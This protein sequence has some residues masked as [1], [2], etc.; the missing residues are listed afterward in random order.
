V[1]G[2]RDAFDR[3]NVDVHTSS[4]EIEMVQR[5][6]RNLTAIYWA[7]ALVGLVGFSVSLGASLW[8]NI[9]RKRKELSV[10]RL[11]GFRTADIIW[12]PMVQALF[13][14]VLGWALA[15]AI[16]QVTA[17]VINDML[18]AQLE[19]GVQVCRLLP[20]HYAIAL[21][22]TC[23]AAVFAAGLAGLRSARIEPSEGLRDL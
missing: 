13:T 18:A 21:L 16:Y 14:A 5:M 3:L 10:L 12:F 23:I 20:L 1:A 4:A 22:L 9:D 19:T 17:L 8:A 2:L 6:N 7:I 11:V 15:L